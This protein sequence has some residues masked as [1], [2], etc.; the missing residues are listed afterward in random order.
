M[1]KEIA[2]LWVGLLRSGEFIQGKAKLRSGWEGDAKSFCCIGVLCEL[3]K[4]E[5]PGEECGWNENNEFLVNTGE[6]DP[7]RGYELMPPVVMKWAGMRSIGGLYNGDRNSLDKDNDNGQTF[8][9]IA[10]TIEKEVASL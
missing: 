9:Q 2:K 10:D 6:P 7:E 8:A 5:H 1:N 3:Y 4:R